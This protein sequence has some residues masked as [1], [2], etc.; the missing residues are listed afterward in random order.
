MDSPW[1]KKTSRLQ[2]LMLWSRMI[3]SVVCFGAGNRKIYTSDLRKQN[4]HC[5]KLFRRVVCPP[6]GIDWNQPWHTILHAW[7]RRIDQKLEYHSFK[8]LSPKYYLKNMEYNWPPIHHM[9]RPFLLVVHFISS[10]IF[11]SSKKSVYH[12]HFGLL[13]KISGYQP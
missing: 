8:I 13:T 6:P 3:T 4:V 5:R 9:Y 12:L 1:Q 11:G 2:F 7:H 10:C